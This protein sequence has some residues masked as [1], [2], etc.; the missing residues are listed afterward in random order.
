MLSPQL[1]AHLSRIGDIVPIAALLGAALPLWAFLEIA[2]EVGEGEARW[3]DEALLMSL[4]T[5]DPADP[6]GPRWLETAI[7]DL[8]ALGGFAVLTLLT[9]LAVGYLLVLKKGA[10]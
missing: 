7:M 6:V 5:A 4:R 10:D 3:F 2:D 8:T 1:R 9:L